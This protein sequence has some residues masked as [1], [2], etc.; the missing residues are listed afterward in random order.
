MNLWIGRF[1]EESIDRPLPIN[2]SNNHSIN[3]VVRHGS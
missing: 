1:D 3:K 2:N